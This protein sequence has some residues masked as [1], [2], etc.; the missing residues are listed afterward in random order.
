MAEREAGLNDLPAK[1]KVGYHD[2]KIETWHPSEASGARRYGETNGISRTIRID[3]SFSPR[4]TAETLLHEILH[5]ICDIWNIEDEDK[6]ERVV[7]AM[8]AGLATVWRDNPDVLS[9]ID[10]NLLAKPVE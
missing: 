6:E 8:S 2:Y 4:Q 9:F 7:S 5:C 10:M 3:T 1:V